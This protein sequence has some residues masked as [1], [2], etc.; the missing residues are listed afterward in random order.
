MW[1]QE[2]WFI[3]VLWAQMAA[4]QWKA[5]ATGDNVCDTKTSRFE[6]CDVEADERK[7]KKPS[8]WREQLWFLT[9]VSPPWTGLL[10][11]TLHICHSTLA[12]LTKQATFWSNDWKNASD[13][14]LAAHTGNS[15]DL[16]L[17][18][19]NV[20]CV[21]GN[22]R[23]VESDMDVYQESCIMGHVGSHTRFPFSIFFFISGTLL[24]SWPPLL[25]E[26][27]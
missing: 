21:R 26:T 24:K 19:N 14:P 23:S 20:K 5:S 25:K 17:R 27:Q 10:T 11:S 22:L 4:F 13:W 3:T 8:Y 12:P 9:G 18:C 2:G 7:K 16:G 6:A 1:K 15:V